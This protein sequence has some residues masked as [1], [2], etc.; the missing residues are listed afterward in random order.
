M[1]SHLCDCPTIGADYSTVGHRLWSELIGGHFLFRAT[2][3]SESVAGATRRACAASAP[4]A[5][6]SLSALIQQRDHVTASHLL[7]Q[8]CS[9]CGGLLLGK[10]LGGI[11]SCRTVARTRWSATAETNE[12]KVPFACTH[13][14]NTPRSRTGQHKGDMR[15][16]GVTG[17]CIEDVWESTRRMSSLRRGNMGHSAPGI[18]GLESA[19]RCR[20]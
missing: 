3:M 5:V 19:D 17:R 6:G 13:V 18:C 16:T 9:G 4:A 8:C 15:A 10:P 7:L 2:L 20:C 1:L 11:V 14:P 12:R